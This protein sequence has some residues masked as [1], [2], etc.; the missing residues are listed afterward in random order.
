MQVTQRNNAGGIPRGCRAANAIGPLCLAVPSFFSGNIFYCYLGLARTRAADDRTSSSFSSRSSLL[1]PRWHTTTTSPT[2]PPRFC[3]HRL[4][5][6]LHLSLPRP[7]ARIHEHLRSKLSTTT[8]RDSK[9][10]PPFPAA[11]IIPFR[12]FSS[13]S[14]S[15]RLSVSLPPA[16][17]STPSCSVPRLAYSHH[18]CDPC[19]S[20]SFA[21]VFRFFYPRARI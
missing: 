12:P 21:R 16:Q 11:F 10:S 17:F 8:Q 5:L 6:L 13:P 15:V 4:L 9:Y 1:H 3:D 19:I 14:V 2:S 18:R 20:V 7:A